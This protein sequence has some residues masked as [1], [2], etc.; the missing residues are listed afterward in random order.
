L[1]EHKL[2]ALV[3]DDEEVIRDFLKQLLSLNGIEVEVAEN[4]LKA[5]D[6]AQKQEFDIIFLDIRMPDMDGFKALKELKGI[7]PKSKYVMMTGYSVDD[8]LE[9]IEEGVIGFIK[10]PFEIDKIMSQINEIQRLK[11]D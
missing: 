1:E 7:N 8:L 2:K 3:V 9:G 10:K 4:G 11:K 5:I 6:A